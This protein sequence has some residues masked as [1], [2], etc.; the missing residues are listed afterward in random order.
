MAVNIT[1]D[2]RQ[3][4]LDKIRA[5]MA[6]SRQKIAAMK[7]KKARG[8]IVL[9]TGDNAEEQQ[10]S[11][12][13][14]EETTSL[15]EK[16]KAE[17]AA[18]NS[19][20]PS[21]VWNFSNSEIMWNFIIGTQS[22]ET[23][24]EPSAGLD[25]VRKLSVANDTRQR[26]PSISKRFQ[27]TAKPGDVRRPSISQDTRRPSISDGRRPSIGVRSRQPSIDQQRPAIGTRMRQPSVDQQRP[28]IRSSC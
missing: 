24:N 12:K 14:F 18:K 19:G 3:A 15:V 27:P 2:D 20:R 11:A 16:L 26:A 21:F 7:E 17:R 4:L 5:D 1:D 22:Q 13:K 25:R 28:S 9:Q 23:V 6:A 10:S 8:T